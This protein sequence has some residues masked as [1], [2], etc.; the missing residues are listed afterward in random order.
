MAISDFVR[1]W[2]IVIWILHIN[3]LSP[4]TD[5]FQISF[6]KF[7]FYKFGNKFVKYIL[8]NYSRFVFRYFHEYRY[9]HFHEHREKTDKLWRILLLEVNKYCYLETR[10]LKRYSRRLTTVSG[11]LASLLR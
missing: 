3:Q 8:K 9:F 7:L 10:R 2:C 1:I 6:S 4:E 11:E 5:N